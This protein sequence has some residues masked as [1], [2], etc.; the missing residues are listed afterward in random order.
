MKKVLVVDDA[1]VVRLMM[2]KVLKEGG[3]EIVGEATNGRE[4]ITQ[5][6]ELHPD[7]V[8]MDMVMPDADGIQA[9]REIVAFDKNAKV[10]MVSGIEQKEMLMKA[11]Q[12][13]ASSYI[14]K[15][16][17]A[18]RVILTLNEVLEH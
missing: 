1:S 3:F 4:A 13:G 10:V 12:A 18:D 9:T 5:F 11:I 2:K 8:T 17:D 6:K 16:F 14:V 7:I 15:P